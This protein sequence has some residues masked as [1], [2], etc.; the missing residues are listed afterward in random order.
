[1]KSH[2]NWGF[3]V[4]HFQEGQEGESVEL[5][6]RPPHLNP[7]EDD[8]ENNPEKTFETYDVEEGS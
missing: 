3:P 5:Q 7:W 2:G 4:T 8:G 6:A 1:L